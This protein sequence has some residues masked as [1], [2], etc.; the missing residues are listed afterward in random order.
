MEKYV[1]KRIEGITKCYKETEKAL[2][3][4]KKNIS[5]NLEKDKC[6]DKI[7]RWTNKIVQKAVN[8]EPETDHTKVLRINKKYKIE[9]EVHHIINGLFNLTYYILD[10]ND[11]AIDQD[12][13]RGNGFYGK[14]Y[15]SID[16]LLGM[17]Y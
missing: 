17:Y 4:Y 5:K 16:Y 13:S 14:T 7:Q 9:I 15:D 12:V 6:K 3:N 11:N 8:S 2:D 10:N 1:V